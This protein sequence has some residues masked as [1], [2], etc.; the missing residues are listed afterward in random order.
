[1]PSGMKVSLYHTQLNLHFLQAVS[2][3]L[4]HLIFRVRVRVFQSQLT[5]A[6]SNH[7]VLVPNIRSFANVQYA[8][9]VSLEVTQAF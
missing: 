4:W 3:S 8:Y 1:M 6:A 9:R 7:N 5:L 2:H